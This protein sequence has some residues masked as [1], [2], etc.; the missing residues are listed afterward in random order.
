MSTRAI[1]HRVGLLL[2]LTPATLAA[3]AVCS[4]PHSSPM[5]AQGGG[6]GTLDPGSGWVQFSANSQRADERFDEFGTRETFFLNARTTTRSLYATAAVGV[7]WG[8]DVWAQATLHR[9]RYVDDGGER[10]R[11]G[12]GDVRLAAR[13]SSELLGLSIPVS[14]RAGIK[15][16]GSDFPV[17]ATVIPLTEGQADLEVSVE[18]GHASAGGGLY[19]LAWVG[20][21][22]R[23]A[24]DVQLRDPGDEWFGHA[25]VG[26]SRGPPPVGGWSRCA[27]RGPRAHPGARAAQ[28]SETAAP[29]EARPLAPVRARGGRPGPSASAGR[30]KPAQQPLVRRQLPPLVVR[31]SLCS[32]TA[33][34]GIHDQASALSLMGPCTAS[35]G[36][37]VVA[38]CT[39]VSAPVPCSRVA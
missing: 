20:Y 30:S 6:I 39:G 22:W 29:G 26:G 37:G 31:G 28:R 15:I 7:A 27:Q 12:L 32:W 23:L 18:T 25:A 16:P 33:E 38:G 1:T 8:V 19:V 13:A 4:A 2:L 14:V 10:S 36:H 21:R 5:L 34:V 35:R 9:L 17:D 24:S 3:Q 11:T